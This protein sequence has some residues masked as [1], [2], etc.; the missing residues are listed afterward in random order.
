[1]G[2]RVPVYEMLTGC[3]VFAGATVGEILGEVFKGEPDWRRLLLKLLPA[4]AACC[5]AVY[6]RSATHGCADIADARLEI[7]E[8]Q[9]EPPAAAD[10]TPAA[11]QRRGNV[12]C[13]RLGAGHPIGIQ[14]P[15]GLSVPHR[16]RRRRAWISRLRQR[17]AQRR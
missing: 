1:M 7:D 3:R 12:C 13:G 10:M 4:S 9:A 5:A 15:H 11:A 8:A 6:R 2:I 14:Q 16:Q 17:A